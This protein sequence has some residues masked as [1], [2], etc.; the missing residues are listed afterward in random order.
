MH[1]LLVLRDRARVLEDGRAVDASHDNGT[2]LKYFTVDSSWLADIMD[3]IFLD[4]SLGLR[5][6]Y[7]HEPVSCQ[8]VVARSDNI[9]GLDRCRH[10]WLR[11]SV[12]TVVSAR[13]RASL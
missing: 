10:G 3:N 1:L 7:W 5:L 4:H 8:L 9:F 13:C 6:V 2:S 11:Y 12:Q